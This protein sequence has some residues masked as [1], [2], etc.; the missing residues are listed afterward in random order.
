MPTKFSKNK[1]DSTSNL[2]SDANELNSVAGM[3]LGHDDD[4]YTNCTI[5]INITN[6]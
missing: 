1:P 4:N 6:N 5:T 3:R 2:T